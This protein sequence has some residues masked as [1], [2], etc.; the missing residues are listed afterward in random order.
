V[1]RDQIL[2]AVGP[3]VGLPL[4]IAR[5]AASMRVLHFGRVTEGEDGSWGAF[6]LHLQCPWRLEGPAGM[7]TGQDDLWEHPTLEV[8]PEDWSWDGADTRQDVRVGALLGARDERT[9]S[10]VNTSP[11][12]L[13]VTAV[14]ASELGDLFITF[15]GGYSLRVFPA[16]ESGEAWRFL[17]PGRGTPHFVVSFT[18]GTVGSSTEA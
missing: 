3:L 8:P 4:S 12:R 16:S 17:A 14:E 10:W 18:D 9:R 6:A 13:V 7:V 11:D 2:T 5:R 1:L 15:S